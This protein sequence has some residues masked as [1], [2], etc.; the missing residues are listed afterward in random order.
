MLEL[1]ILGLLKEEPLHGYELKKRLG[2]ALGFLWGVSYGS[3]YPALRRLER[4][5]AIEIVAPK[6]APTV[7]PVPMPATGSIDD[8][9]AAARLRR[10][11]KPTRRTRK[12]YRLT[13]RGHELFAEQL[14]A[15]DAPGADDEKA[16][17]LKV[18][19]CRHLSSDARIQLLERRRAGLNERLAQ[20]RGTTPRRGDRYLRSLAE[21]RTESTARDLAWVEELIAAERRADHPEPSQKGATAS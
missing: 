10:I 18:A 6:P 14:R 15:E 12:Q 5:G 8:E 2:E 11:P 21:H 19:F 9:T 4:A 13:E 20:A 17:A 7:A 3:L 1:A 16:F